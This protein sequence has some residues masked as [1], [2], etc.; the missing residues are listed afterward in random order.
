MIFQ[1]VYAAS[2]AFLLIYL[3]YLRL[4]Y[5][6]LKNRNVNF[7]NSKPF[8]SV[9]VA[10]RNEKQNIA[11]LLTTLVNQTYPADKFQ[12]II[13]NDGSTDG[14]SLIVEK[15][16]QKWVKIKLLNVT[17]RNNAISPKKNALSQ[18][19]E[20]AEGEIILS[21]DA[22]CLVG[23][24]WIE[25]MVSCFDDN[26]MV[27]GFSRTKL[28]DWSKANFIRKFEHF[29]FL[30]MLFAAAGAISS[31]KYFSC[32]GQN[33]AYKKEAFNK[34]GGFEKIKHLI[35]GD[36]V[37]LMQLFRKSGMKVSFAFTDHSYVYT[38]PIENTGKFLNQRSRWTS[39]MKWQ[40]LLNPEFFIY[41]LSVFLITFLPIII[42]F[43]FWQLGIVL[44][45]LR[46]SL[47]IIFLKYGYKVFG[48]DK[49]KLMYYPVW[50]IMQPLYIITI[51]VMSG[52]NIFSWKK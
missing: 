2:I 25:S 31:Q 27:I 44:L 1:I 52:L 12:I 14:T 20:M 43:N 50:F 42:L 35:S 39:N 4:F 9:V 37:N 33:I 38:Q 45:L 18:A 7:V 11:R 36:D 22:D 19:I 29:D 26:E 16:S 5:I 6:G 23:K 49:K 32:S 47:E 8:V 28:T 21:T 40:I 24:Y 15:F 30:A 51:A 17:G 41:L 46:M 34:V 48:E 10:A 3:F 13:A